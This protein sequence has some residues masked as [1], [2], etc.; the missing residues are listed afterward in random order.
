MSEHFYEA[1]PFL[2][3]IL[4]VLGLLFS[5]DGVG[6]VSSVLLV[7]AALAIFKIRLNYRKQRAESAEYRLTKKD[8]ST[9]R[10]S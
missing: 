9:I 8:T 6:R 5:G 7:T 4:G 2:Y 1:L 3:V 10:Y